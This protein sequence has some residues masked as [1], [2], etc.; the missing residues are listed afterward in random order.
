M[1]AVEISCG[2]LPGTPHHQTLPARLPSMQALADCVS[3]EQ[4]A[5]KQIYPDIKD[6]REVSATV[7]ARRSC[8]QCSP[9]FRPSR[10]CFGG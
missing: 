9:S 10:A 6:L 3:E 1:V 5:K 4:L 8:A 2:I 7:G